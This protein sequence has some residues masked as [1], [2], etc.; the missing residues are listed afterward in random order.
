MNPDDKVV[1]IRNAKVT[2]KIA[3]ARPIDGPQ[4]PDGFVEVIM[5][6]GGPNRFFRETDLRAAS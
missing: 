1:A 2:G 6:A 4:V 5:D 3:P